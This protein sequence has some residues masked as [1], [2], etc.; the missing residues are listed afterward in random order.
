MSDSIFEVEHHPD[1]ATVLRVKSP[2]SWKMSDSTMQHLSAAQKEILLALRGM[3]DKA[4]EITEEFEKPK[5]KR[6]TKINI[7]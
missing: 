4:I 6:K 7:Q 5:A 1:G 3:I 2:K